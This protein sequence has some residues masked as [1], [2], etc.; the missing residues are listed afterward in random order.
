M[1][2]YGKVYETGLGTTLVSTFSFHTAISDVSTDGLG[3][4]VFNTR[5]LIMH[6]NSALRDH[7]EAYRSRWSRS[8]E[9]GWSAHANHP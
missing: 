1:E 5:A 7:Q 3:R 6:P 2:P 8:L 9:L 4:N